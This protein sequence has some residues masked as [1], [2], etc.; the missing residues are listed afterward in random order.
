M[1]FLMNSDHSTPPSNDD[2]PTRAIVK[3]KYTATGTKRIFQVQLQGHLLFALEEYA[4]ENN[5]SNTDAFR[6]LLEFR[7]FQLGKLPDWWYERGV[8]LRGGTRN[9]K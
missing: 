1:G 8:L 9:K 6:D 2:T 4:R 5:I 3:E 7:L